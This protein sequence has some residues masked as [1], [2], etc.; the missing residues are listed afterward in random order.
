MHDERPVKESGVDATGTAFKHRHNYP[1]DDVTSGG[2]I[3]P[4]YG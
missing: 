2:F 4:D 1:E 3:D